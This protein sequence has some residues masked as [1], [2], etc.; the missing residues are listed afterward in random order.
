MKKITIFLLL[1]TLVNTACTGEEKFK[2][3]DFTLIFNGENLEGWNP[4]V[5]NGDPELAKKV[6]AVDDGMLH[7][8]NDEFAEEYELGGNNATHGMMYTEKEYSRYILRFEYKWGTKKTNNFADLQ[9][10]AGCYYH[11]TNDKIWPVGLE[12]QIRYNHE[13]DKNHTGDYYVRRGP[14]FN[15]FSDGEGS[16]LMIRDG[17]KATPRQKLHHP[18]LKNAPHSA[19][20]GKWEECEIIVMGSEYSIHKLNGVIVN[21]GT[22]IGYEKG[23]IGM[24]S[25]TAE[26]FYRNIRILEL[27]ESIP[28]EYFF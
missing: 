10:D 20:K 4:K 19:L 6:F 18:A 21:M 12:Y 11:V 17:G 16:F 26:I 24:Q 1:L 7:I 9:Y 5:K 25:E 2:D 8:F 13:E 3:S 23:L 14:K 28:A 15:W 27:E 22:E